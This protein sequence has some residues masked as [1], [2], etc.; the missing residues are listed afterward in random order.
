IAFGA[1]TSAPGT[2]EVVNALRVA[3]CPLDEVACTRCPGLTLCERPCD[4]V[5]PTNDAE[6]FW[7][8]LAPGERSAV[9]RTRSRAFLRSDEQAQ[10]PWY[11]QE[12]HTVGFFYLR[13]ANEIARVELPLWAADDPARVSLL[14]A[15]LLDQCAKGPGYPVVLQEAHEQAVITT[16]DRRSFTALLEREIEQSGAIPHGSAKSKSKRVRSI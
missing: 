8:L 3:A 4:E 14:H 1:Y 9:F 12:G 2:S 13:V 16:V 15:A 5:G 11:E 10:P 7:S 6:L